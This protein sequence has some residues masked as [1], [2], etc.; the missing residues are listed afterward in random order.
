VLWMCRSSSLSIPSVPLALR[1]RSDHVLS[2][3]Q[4]LTGL[5]AVRDFQFNPLV[6]L[7]VAFVPC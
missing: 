5:V 7:V 4:S 1:A 2:R 3:S 6:T